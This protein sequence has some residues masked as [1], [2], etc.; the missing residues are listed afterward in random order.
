MKYLTEQNKEE[1]RGRRIVVRL[2]LN[3][4]IRDGEIQGDFRLRKSL[5]TIEWLRD[6]GAQIILLSHIKN[7]EGSTLLPV[8]SWLKQQVD[9]NI[10][11]VEDVYNHEIIDTILESGKIVLIENLRNW[12]GETE[13]HVEFAEYLSSLGEVFVQDA[14]AVSHRPHA[15]V[16]GIQKILPTIY[17]CQIE[18]EVKALSRIFDPERPLVMIFGGI[19]FETKLPLI[20]KYLDD[21]DKL[22][23]VGG[24][25]NDVYIDVYG[26]EIGIS[27]YSEE[28]DVS[29]LKGNDRILIPEQVSVENR[30]GD[31]RVT[32]VDEIGKEECI[33]DSHP[34][35]IE[36][37]KEVIQNAGTIVW[38]G[39]LGWYEKGYDAG[40]KRMA[41]MIAESDA[42]SVVGGGD[43]IA[44]IEQL[45]L[46]DNFDFLSTGGGAMLEY[47]EKEGLVG[48]TKKT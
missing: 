12:D 5:E 32:K 25:A 38:N 8:F 21:A 6:A 44:A 43:T 40:T 28:I 16:V 33:M 17:G 36:S 24:M 30:N 4:P 23:I 7:K 15:S 14:F 46:Q 34:L 48:L 31:S 13:N 39:P 37:F 11:F 3:V 19:K 22:I 10:S 26:Y 20:Q 35:G 29:F 1:Y 41:Q 9:N 18:K 45:G 2:D 27:M 47:L 42:Y